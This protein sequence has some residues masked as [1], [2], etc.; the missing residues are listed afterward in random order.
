[1]RAM[2]HYVDD[3]G[4]WL[5][6]G[7]PR[8]YGAGDWQKTSLEGAAPVEMIP[9]DRKRPLALLL[10]LDKSGSMAHESGGVQKLTLAASA[11]RAAIDA[12]D[13]EDHIAVVAFDAKAHVAAELTA[14]D[15][16]ASVMRAVQGLRPGA[17]T[18]IATAL[19]EADRLLTTADFPRKHV[20]L[21][22]DGQ[23]EG[24]LVG[25]ARDLA[26]KRIT[27]STVAV[28]AD[29]KPVL[30]EIAEAGGGSFHAMSDM[31]HLPRVF[32][33]EARQTGDVVVDEATHAVAGSGALAA[34]TYPP[35]AAYLAT[36]PKKT[37]ETF[38]ETVEGDPILVGWR[39]GLGK[40]L[41]FMSDGG[42]R[43]THDWA[44]EPDYAARWRS[45]LRW[46]LPEGR[47]DT[48][49]FALDVEGSTVVARLAYPPDGPPPAR[50]RL[51]V[52]PQDGG[53]IER[54]MKPV[55]NGYDARVALRAPGGYAIAVISDESEIARGTIEYVGSAESLV[56]PRPDR[57]LALARDSGGAVA[58]EPGSW[59][60][61]TGAGVP[62][63]RE[64]SPAL[65]LLAIAV[66]FLE[67]VVRHFGGI[68]ATR[69]RDRVDTRLSALSRA[70]RRADA[71]ARPLSTRPE[72][73]SAAQPAAQTTTAG[74]AAS[75]LDRLQAA[76]GRARTA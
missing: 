3:G 47:P 74:D 41:A 65:L 34:G 53:P 42:N 23:S 15:E 68:R 46:T 37:A 12:L 18:D 32:A 52:A 49:D 70:K 75:G 13:D 38:L 26:A 17:G 56:A 64:L 58:P 19:A 71:I 50:L 33:E 4:A 9:Q 57:L 43:W 22:S 59:D 2:A 20:V 30:R 54:E 69:S 67:W 35:F 62:H 16:G 72:A 63:E 40:A 60:R 66:V 39:L 1:M 7:G 27:V 51:R 21:L 8:T 11:T 45:W 55:G 61:R 36:T 14:K 31:S 28:G 44:A 25:L 6:I 48:F 76:K 24:D 73:R 5:T 10:L 29:A